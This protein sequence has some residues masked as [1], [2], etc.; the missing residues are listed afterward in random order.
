V[1]LEGFH[2]SNQLGG[3]D[4]QIPSQMERRLNQPGQ[5][6]ES[7]VMNNSWRL[8]HNWRGESL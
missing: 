2:A 8:W 6:V 5:Q 4:K 3:Q 1:P 7:T